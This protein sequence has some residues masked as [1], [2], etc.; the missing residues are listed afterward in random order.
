MKV[1]IRTF[2]ES[3]YEKREKGAAPDDWVHVSHT[4]SVDSQAN[5]W[6]EATGN[7]IISVSPPGIEH[8][9]ADKEMTLKCILVGMT[10]CYVEAGENSS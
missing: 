6:V 8:V 10:V 4:E 1:K 3:R 2:I 7:N 9:W 5:A